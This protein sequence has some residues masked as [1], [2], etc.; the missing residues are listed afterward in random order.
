VKLSVI[1][2]AYN[3]AILI[4]DT[5]DS[6]LNSGLD[7]FEIVVVDDGSTDQTPDLVRAMSA[8]VRYLRQ[9]NAGLASARNTGFAASCGRYVAFLDSDDLWFPGAVPTLLR[10][11]ENHEDIPFIFGDAQMGSPSAGFVSFVETFG[12]DEFRNLPSREICSGVHRFDR[13]PFFRQLARRNG[14][15]LGSM[16]MRREIVDQVGPFDP[17]PYGAE[18]WHF[19]LRLALRYDFYYCEA[20]PVSAY[21]QHS[22]NMTK[23]QDR[24]ND[25]FCKALS[26]LLEEPG[27]TP[28]ERTHV[29]IHL[30][31]CKF[32][33]AYPAYD[34]GDF[35]AASERF[36]DCLRSGFAWNPFFYWLACQ[37]PAPVLARARSLKQRYSEEAESKPR[38]GQTAGQ[39]SS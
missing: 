26:R 34:R 38:L 22:T 36:F 39:P 32:G 19:F 33:Y 13:G 17:F 7:D 25:G 23:S 31:R 16:V 29:K 24:M 8:P 15:F 2:P 6:I 20:L 14:V 35:Q 21:I 4:S 9:E 3:R 12:G 30:K 5:I 1:I 28:S 11:L 18:D 27:L 37:L 10:H